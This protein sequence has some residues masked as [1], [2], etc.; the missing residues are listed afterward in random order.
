M[1]TCVNVNKTSYFIVVDN[2]PA[3]ISE[4]FKSYC[5]ERKIDVCYSSVYNY[6]SHGLVERAHQTITRMVAASIHGKEK[7]NLN[8]AIFDA[9]LA[10]NISVHRQYKHIPA[11]IYHGKHIL[12]G[13]TRALGV[14]PTI[15]A[16]QER[17]L[18]RLQYEKHRDKMDT[19]ADDHNKFRHYKKKDK[20]LVKV[21]A[22][23]K[24]NKKL[25]PRYDG[26]YEVLSRKS[27]WS[28]MVVKLNDLMD[29]YDVKPIKV[30]VR[31]LKPY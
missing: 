20:V 13:A 16:E 3:F 28:Y 27:R 25:E 6:T 9:V 26:P 24:K 22:E 8:Q 23:G 19:L 21:M 4:L 5:K 18:L 14:N 17:N 29:G 10:Y 15:S 7:Y 1:K 31:S 30:N 11:N 12:D 2:G